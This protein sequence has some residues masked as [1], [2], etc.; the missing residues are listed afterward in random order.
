MYTLCLLKIRHN[1]KQKEKTSGHDTSCIGY[2]C[3]FSE[4]DFINV[5]L[6]VSVQLNGR[7]KYYKNIV[8][9]R[10]SATVA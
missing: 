10:K 8:E 6:V 3:K 9:H 4:S 7:H 1:R 5:A 2:V